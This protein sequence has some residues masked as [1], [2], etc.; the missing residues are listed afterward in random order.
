MNNEE[1]EAAVDRLFEIRDGASDKRKDRDEL[2]QEISALEKEG[3]ELRTKIR[4]EMKRRNLQVITT[5]ND[6]AL[7]VES[8]G[9]LDFGKSNKSYGLDDPP[10]ETKKESEVQS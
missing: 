8:G 10:E 1:F 4:D 7:I 6:E 5:V 9:Y 3:N 2:E